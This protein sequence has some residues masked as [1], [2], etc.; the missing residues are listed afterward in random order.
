[1]PISTYQNALT[2]TISIVFLLISFILMVVAIRSAFA[3]NSQIERRLAGGAGE[4]LDAT[5][6]Q[7]PSLLTTLSSHLTLPSE[8]DI[9]RLRF[10]LSQAGF[11]SP[12]AVQIYHTVRVICL[13]VPQLFLLLAISR[14]TLIMSFSAIMLLFCVSLILSLFAPVLYIRHLT[15]KRR[16]QC[17]NGFPDMM[18]LLI[19]CIEAGLGMNAALTLCF[20]LAYVFLRGFNVAVYPHCFVGM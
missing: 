10:Q 20:P 19:A 17:R 18:D 14:L 9:T 5:L 2:I 11:Y 13:F 15:R 3:H 8:K 6:E 4:N 16:E 12:T 1:M 7:K